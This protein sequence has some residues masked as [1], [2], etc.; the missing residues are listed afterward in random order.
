[1]TERRTYS[2]HGL[3]A[4]KVRVAVRGLSAI[5]QR[6]LAGRG[7]VVWQKELIAAL[8]GEASITPQ[9]REIIRDCAVTKLLRDS[10]DAW[11]LSQPSLINLRKRALLPVVKERLQIAD[12]LLKSLSLLGLDRKAV[13]PPDL[14]ALLASLPSEE[15]QS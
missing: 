3:T 2:R 5:D 10:I 4:L 13:D 15:V 7:L 9:K 6:T 12:H 14:A 1:M 8:G 11:L